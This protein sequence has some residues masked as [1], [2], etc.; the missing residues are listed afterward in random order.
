MHTIQYSNTFCFP[1][2]QCKGNRDDGFKR[3]RVRATMA[4]SGQDLRLDRAP[5]LFFL[6]GASQQSCRPFSSQARTDLSLQ[7]HKEKRKATTVADT[8]TPLKNKE[9]IV[10]P[11]SFS[12]SFFFKKKR[13]HR[14]TQEKEEG[15]CRAAADGQWID[16]P[17][18][19]CDLLAKGALAN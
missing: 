18:G 15:E 13:L 11:S 2:L 1:P 14:D 5:A 16:R 3:E 17:R 10:F 19:L 9:I 7:E 8:P 12:S 4:P 6:A